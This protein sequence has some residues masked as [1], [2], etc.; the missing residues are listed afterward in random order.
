MRSNR[1]FLDLIFGLL[2]Y[3]DKSDRKLRGLLA[4]MKSL[5]S[6]IRTFQFLN[7]MPYTLGICKSVISNTFKSLLILNS[8]NIGL[9]LQASTIVGFRVGI[10]F[11]TILYFS[12]SYTSHIQHY[13]H[14]KLLPFVKVYSEV[15]ISTSFMDFGI[16]FAFKNLM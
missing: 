14:N 4:F 9:K 16:I 1:L 15:T 8:S 11:K 3:Q 7:A 6:V 10:F 5:V 2:L 13:K 12:H